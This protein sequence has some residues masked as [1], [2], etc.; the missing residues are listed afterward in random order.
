[1]IKLMD[2]VGFGIRMAQHMRATGPTT[3]K[4]DRVMKNGMMVVI[5]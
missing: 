1:M 4:K 3:N 5:S 2:M